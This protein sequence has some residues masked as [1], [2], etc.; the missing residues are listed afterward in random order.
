MAPAVAPLLLLAVSVALVAAEDE[1]SIKK[2]LV[3][4]YQSP[5][6][7][8]GVVKARRE[9]AAANG[10]CTASASSA[11]PPDEVQVQIY[12]DKYEPLDMVQQ[13]WGVGGYLR[14]LWNDPQL[15]YPGTADGGCTDE[16]LFERIQSSQF[17]SPILYFEEA[18]K[19]TVPS[20]KAEDGY[21]SMFSVSPNGD[22]FW[23]RQFEVQVFCKMFSAGLRGI[24]TLPF[25]TQK[26]PFVLGPYAEDA[27]KVKVRW[28]DGVSHGFSNFDGPCLGEWTILG[29]FEE[30]QSIA[31]VGKNYTYAR[32]ELHFAR[33]PE[34]WLWSYMLPSVAITLLQYL[35][36]FIDTASTPARVSL[37]MVTLLVVMTKSVIRIRTRAPCPTRALS[38]T[39]T[40][41]LRLYAAK[42][43]TIESR[44]RSFAALI[45]QLPALSANLPWLG[46]FLLFSFIF[47]LAA[48]ME[49]VLVSFG[50]S[51]HK[52]LLEQHRMLSIHV[53]WQTL[54]RERSFEI[55]R[56]F[57]DWDVD[58]NGKIDRPEFRRALKALG[59]K[60]P[61]HEMN[62]LFDSL[63]ADGD[64]EISLDELEEK[65]G[66]ATA[67]ESG[68]PTGSESNAGS[69]SQKGVGLPP[70]WNGL[71]NDDD[72]DDDG[73]GEPGV[74]LPGV[75]FGRGGGG[76]NGVGDSRTAQEGRRPAKTANAQGVGSLSDGRSKQR[77][78]DS[79]RQSALA[80]QNHMERRPTSSTAPHPPRW[81]PAHCVLATHEARPR[82]IVPL[83]G[84]NS[85]GAPS[86][87]SSRP[88]GA[89]QFARGRSAADLRRPPR[90][91]TE[92]EMGVRHIGGLR[93]G[94]PM[95]PRLP[96][97]PPASP[98]ASPPRHT[99]R[100]APLKRGRSIGVEQIKPTNSSRK[101]SRDMANSYSKAAM[102]NLDKGWVWRFKTFTLFPILV[103][104]RNLDFAMRGIFPIAY[105]AFVLSMFREVDFGQPHFEALR[106]AAGSCR[107]W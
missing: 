26:C 55:S 2:R 104:L 58:R 12:V 38:D 47:N 105:L 66:T 4:D 5:S 102:S 57:L 39:S 46:Q 63:D 87:P 13:T 103:Q 99:P 92:S 85:E 20:E 68:G 43:R 74:H 34:I 31:Y 17:W 44:S 80:S 42:G 18:R 40:Q 24:E 90:Q 8:P 76:A 48:M 7:R 33:N 61:F 89:A 93:I 96:P 14:L 82:T 88:H 3:R 97:S 11:V 21:A 37:G 30:T 22:V 83:Y 100:A 27:S 49:Q 52:W 15:A 10:T 67:G 19:V 70:A 107:G 35:G 69:T 95:S 71:H 41:G 60:A 59:I 84:A 94:T 25:D 9:A 28:R 50:I 72:D 36:F 79:H 98:P 29:V 78:S 51:A 91:P 65:L 62:E 16:L 53:H 56:L 106:N 86:G 75:H 81:S 54:V 6:T 64:G 45:R 73:E 101:L 23:S 77:R 1:I 32:A